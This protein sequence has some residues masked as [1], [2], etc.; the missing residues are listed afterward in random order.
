MDAVYVATD[1]QRICDVV[2]GFGGRVIMTSPN[3][4]SGTDRIAEAWRKI[5][6]DADVVINVQGDE[7]FVHP[8]QILEQIFNEIIN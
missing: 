7:P 6:S 3:H 2:T 5:N 8:S 4:K 1:D